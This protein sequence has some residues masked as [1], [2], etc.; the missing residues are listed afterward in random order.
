MR[1]LRVIG[2]VVAVFVA[3]VGLLFGVARLG[4]GP[5][6]PL[7]GGPLEAGEL[8]SEPVAD[9][10]FAAEIAEI[11]LQLAADTTSRTT[12]ILVHE[13]RA[14]IPCSLG[15]PPGKDWY[16]RADRNGDALLRIEGRRYPVRLVR[17]QDEAV[18]SAIREVA[19][20][21]YTAG[22]PGESEVWLFEVSSR[23]S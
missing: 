14:Y 22:P 1:V 15:F 13:G 3:L 23:A 4:D 21:K 7:P 20:T 17:V 18:R 2:I 10:S 6:G 5:L 19:R 11:E 9:W 12:W 8:A 16:L